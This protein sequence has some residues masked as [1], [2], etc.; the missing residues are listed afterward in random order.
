MLEYVFAC[1]LLGIGIAVD[2]SLATIAMYTRFSRFSDGISWAS[3]V[4]TTHILFPMIGYYGF[5]YLYRTLPTL[6]LW[7][8][9]VAAVFIFWFLFSAFAEI[10]EDDE[11]EADNVTPISWAVVLAVSWDALWSGP[12]KSAQALSWTPAEV[13][14]SFIIAGLIVGVVALASVRLA[15]SMNKADNASQKRPTQRAKR[16]TV[17][18]WL[19]FSV[20]GYFGFLA[21]VRYVFDLNRPWPLVLLASAA[22][23]APLFWIRRTRIIDAR[24]AKY[25][26]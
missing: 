10:Q 1:I 3:K 25:C 16:E 6:D 21:L 13:F 7:L 8:G 11:A 23:W 4:T 20:I 12:A 26:E 18:S 9:L 24:A 17:A 22:F 14:W 5:V 15:V 19:E 2:V